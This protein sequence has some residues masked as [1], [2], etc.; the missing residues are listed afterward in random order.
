MYTLKKNSSSPLI[1]LHISSCVVWR[2]HPW[3]VYWI[4]GAHVFKRKKKLIHLR[5]Q[6]WESEKLSHVRKSKEGDETAF[7]SD[8]GNVQRGNKQL[9]FPWCK[10]WVLGHV[11]PFPK[12]ENLRSSLW[13]SSFWEC[14]VPLQQN[15][16]NCT[17]PVYYFAQ[18]T[19]KLVSWMEPSAHEHKDRSREEGRN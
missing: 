19:S 10:P 5:V 6:C 9:P 3:G 1:M 8:I 2:A 15:C 11:S 18:Q 12:R 17:D 13:T 7:P 4:C 14:Y 16:I